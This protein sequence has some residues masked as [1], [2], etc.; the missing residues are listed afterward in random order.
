MVVARDEARRLKV[1]RGYN[2]LDS[3]PEPAF[4]LLAAE[5]AAEFSVPIA[6]VSLVDEHRQW[7]KAAVGLDATETPRS[8]SF[9]THAICGEGVFCVP[10]ALTAPLFENNPLVTGDPNI[11]VYAG[12]PLETHDGHRLGTICVIDREPRGTLSEESRQ[13]LIDLAARVMA[14]IERRQ[15]PPAQ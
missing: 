2:L 8:A 13:S 4:D 6:L 9:C 5:A 7:F 12:A 1:L 10:D 3:K 15:Q 14:Q 11:R